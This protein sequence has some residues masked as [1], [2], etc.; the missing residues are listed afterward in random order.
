MLRSARDGLNEQMSKLFGSVTIGPSKTKQSDKDDADIN[1][2]MKRFGVT[3]QLPLVNMPPSFQDFAGV[4][5]FQS[6]QNLIVGARNAFMALPA[7]VRTRFNNSPELFVAFVEERNSDG[8]LANLADMRKMGLAVP[9]VDPVPERIQK[10][11]VVNA[12]PEGG[13]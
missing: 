8:T 11:E 10:V 9:E 5:D 3:G 12:K 4:F 1:I 6:A 13:F 2:I 7:V